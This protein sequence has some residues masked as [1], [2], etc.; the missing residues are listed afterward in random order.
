MLVAFFSILTLRGIQQI[1]ICVKSK[2]FHKIWGILFIR[3]VF[4][5]NSLQFNTII[6]DHYSAHLMLAI[7]FIRKDDEASYKGT[8]PLR[9]RR[10]QRRSGRHNTIAIF[11]RKDHLMSSTTTHLLPYSIISSVS[12]MHFIVILFT[13]T[14]S[15]IFNTKIAMA[16]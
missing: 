2:V 16:A 13:S 9:R 1:E 10:T 5:S 6:G 3:H 4:S 12:K 14:V 11:N 15:A 8:A 7:M